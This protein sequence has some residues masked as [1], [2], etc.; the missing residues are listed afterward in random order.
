MPTGT[1]RRRARILLIDDDHDIGE[2]VAAILEDEGYE[3]TILDHISDERVR[4]AIGS[5]EPDCVLLDGVRAID[6][7]TTW[8]TAA[9]IHHR[10]RPIPTVMFTAHVR[11]TKE[12]QEGT[13]QR[14]LDAGFA[15]VVPKPFHFDE[16][17]VA[18]ELAVAAGAP[19]NHSESAERGRTDELVAR[20]NAVGARD[21]RPSARREWA[22]FRNS[23]GDEMQLYWWQAAGAYLVARYS[24]DGARLEQVGHYFGLDAAILAATVPSAAK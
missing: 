7:G 18:V 6:Y 19:F 24:T 23:D 8:A 21:V 3:L 16:L 1:E 12:A 15:A 20:L 5:L 13:S 2:I 17:L 14:A 10:S 9:D 22:N 4:A 11:D